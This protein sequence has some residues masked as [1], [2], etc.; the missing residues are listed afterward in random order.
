[1][2]NPI[3]TIKKNSRQIPSSKDILSNANYCDILYGYL[4]NISKRDPKINNCRYVL[5]KNI[6]YS[7]IGRLLGL[8]RQTVSKK[9]K[10][11]LEGE[12][13]SLPLI[14]YNE[15]EGKYYLIDLE[16][17]IATL[18][19]HNTLQVMIS[20]MQTNVLSI[21]VYLLNRYYASKCQQF[22]YYMDQ[23]KQA[24]GLGTKSTGNNYIINSILAILKKI[25]LLNYRYETIKKENQHEK[26]QCY[27]T[28][29]TNQIQGLYYNLN[30]E[31]IIYIYKT[32]KNKIA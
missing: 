31:K 1:M 13:G 3:L 9:F 8:S 26:T 28:W 12:K 14:K 5:K 27:I 21:Y 2:S 20:C 7:Q 6:N 4:Q 24:I 17:S 18:I 19:Q 30:D 11:M 16:A 29:M 22:P 32:L 10:S 23:L 15:D 25:G